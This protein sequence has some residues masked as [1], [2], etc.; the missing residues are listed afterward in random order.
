[1]PADGRNRWSR[2]RGKST[3]TPKRQWSAIEGALLLAALILSGGILGLT[4][5]SVS[6]FQRD[7]P[8]ASVTQEIQL[9]LSEARMGIFEVLGDGKQADPDEVF[10][11]LDHAIT[12]CRA[13]V[14]GGETTSGD[15]A[16]LRDPADVARATTLCR[17]LKSYQGMA[18]T[19]LNNP[20][21]ALPGTAVGGS[22]D[23]LYQRCVTQIDELSV[24]LARSIDRDAGQ[25]GQIGRVLALVVLLTGLGI[26]VLAGRHRRVVARQNAE[27]ATF[28]SL[29]RSSGDAIMT[30]SMTGNIL[31]WNPGAEALYGYTAAEVVG[32]FGALLTSEA[33]LER[34]AEAWMPVARGGQSAQVETVGVR[35]GGAEVAVALRLSPVLAGDTIQAISVISRD[36]SERKA[37]DVELA[38]ARNEALEASRLKSEFLATMSHEIRTPLNGVIGLNAL[39]LQTALDETQRQYAEGV[40][41]AG[42]TLLSVINDI[43]DFS[44]LEADKVEFDVAGFDPRVMLDEVAAL[45]AVGAHLKGLELLAYCSPELPTGLAGDAGR[46]SQ[47]LLNLAGN[48]VKFTASGEV[49]INAHLLESDGEQVVVRFEV[50]DTGIGLAEQGRQ[51]LFESFS[52]ADAS[53]TRRYGGTGLGLAISQRLVDAMGGQIGVDSELGHGSTF[54]FTLPLPLAPDAEDPA[55]EASP[56]LLT[57]LRVL[58]VDDNATNRLI[59]LEQLSNWLMVVEA[60]ADADSALVRLR[61]AAEAGQPYD[62]AVLDL[63]MP[64][65]DGLELAQLMSA[66]PLLAHTRKIMLTSTAH[67]DSAALAAAGIAQWCTKPVRASALYDRLMRLMADGRPVKAATGPPPSLTVPAGSRGHILVAEDN[68]LNQLVAEGLVMALG[69]EVTIVPNGVEALEA[70]SAGSYAA[71]MMDCHMPVMDGFEATRRIR[72]GAA[73]NAHVPVI[74]MTAGALDEDRERCLA[75]GMDDYVSKPVTIEALD[76]VLSRWAGERV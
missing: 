37:K 52:Q 47:V 2:S 44:K 5:N 36:I 34:F 61:A 40:R 26:A 76:A 48:A 7:I 35:K 56:D 41:G 22:M 10:A 38:R 27:L 14:A 18:R 1:V 58:V 21:R 20:A 65:L 59:L 11:D 46:I 70:L 15:L 31:S 8:L 33:E 29:V 67:V 72:E 39:L 6:T 23:A 51:R 13:L 24:S 53:T 75:A 4:G 71:V 16:P 50:R 9:H 42:G 68:E 66:D 19:L 69:F 43:L 28:A 54:W 57:G 32:R 73:S 49:V 25:L 60:V 30:F 63:L 62:I 64:D 12:D 45:V 55:P 3:A 74:A 17:D